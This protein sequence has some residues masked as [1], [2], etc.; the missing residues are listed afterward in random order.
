ML[1][2]VFQDHRTL[3]SGDK[4][5]QGFSPHMDIGGH[6]SLVTRILFYKFMF[7]LPKE[8][9]HKINLAASEK[10]MLENSGHIHVYSPG[11]EADN[12]LVSEFL[13]K[14]KSSVSLAICCKFNP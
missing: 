1:N 11:E 13:Q 6:L 7:S 4:D 9:L 3:G 2:V 8:A 14:H 12:H 5:F 10:N